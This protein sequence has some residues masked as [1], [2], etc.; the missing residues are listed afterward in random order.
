MS[1]LT[2]YGANPDAP[3]LKPLE[4]V[5]TNGVCLVLKT[6][7]NQGLEITLSIENDGP[8]TPKLID[9]RDPAHVIAWFVQTCA[10]ELLPIAAM[11]LHTALSS[12]AQD[13]VDLHA[14]PANDQPPPPERTLAD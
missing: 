12:K 1:D 5:G 7:P 9:P 13:A 2:V 14:A 11:R 8:N 3:I 10:Q 6:K 4:P